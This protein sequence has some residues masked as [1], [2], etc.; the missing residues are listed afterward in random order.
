MTFSIS[1]FLISALQMISPRGCMNPP[2]VL[3][4]LAEVRYHRPPN[5]KV[6]YQRKEKEMILTQ[7]RFILHLVMDCLKHHILSIIAS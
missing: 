5:R 2:H 4:S 7:I 6:N 1:L 3:A